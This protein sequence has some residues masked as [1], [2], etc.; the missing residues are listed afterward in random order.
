VINKFYLLCVIFSGSPDLTL[1]TCL[2]QT[3]S[4]SCQI[5]R[6]LGLFSTN[7]RII[8]NI[9]FHENLSSGGRVFPCVRTDMTKLIVAFRNCALFEHRRYFNIMPQSRSTAN[10]LH[11]HSHIHKQCRYYC[12][13]SGARTQKEN[14]RRL[15]KAFFLKYMHTN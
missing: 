7:F 11:T 10:A 2:V 8:P 1:K 9:T 12:R 15:F 14:L 13:P 5:L 3:S 4:N 6:K